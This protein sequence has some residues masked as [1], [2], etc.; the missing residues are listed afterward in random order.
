MS[1]KIAKVGLLTALALIFSYIEALV[2]FNFGIPGIKLGLANLVIL[3]SLYLLNLKQ[4]VII[5]LL[6]IFISSLLFGSSVS[7]IYSLCGGALSLV[8]MITAKQTK[9][10]SPIGV[11]I[12]GG[13]THNAGQILAA[14]CVMM[15]FSLTYYLPV[16]IIAGVATGSLLGIVACRILSVI[17]RTK[18]NNYL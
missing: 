4:T 12:I 2:P 17:N 16:L 11:S 10:F 3:V 14:F 8:C 9:V 13:V 7:L 18:K 6:R 5:A 1:K 15:S